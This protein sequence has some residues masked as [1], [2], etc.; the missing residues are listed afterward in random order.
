MYLISRVVKSLRSSHV[1]DTAEG[2]LN[3][4]SVIDAKLADG[5]YHLEGLEAACL[6]RR[7]RA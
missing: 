1:A 4:A 6:H 3:T 2:D 5:V 7:D